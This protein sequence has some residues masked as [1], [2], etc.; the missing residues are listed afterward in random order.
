M[1]LLAALLLVALL[2]VSGCN[3]N[4]YW[5]CWDTGSPAPHHAGH[6]IVG[7]HLCSDSELER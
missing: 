2:L 7:D 1:R 6:P 5:Y 4:H 3:R